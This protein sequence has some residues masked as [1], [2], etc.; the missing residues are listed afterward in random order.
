MQIPGLD[1]IFLA[2]IIHFSVLNIFIGLLEGYVLSRLYQDKE[3]HFPFIKMILSNMASLIMFIVGLYGFNVFGSIVLF[4]IVRW[5]FF[6]WVLEKYKS[7]KRDKYYFA[8]SQVAYS[9][10]IVAF[11]MLVLNT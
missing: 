3:L 11:Y 2:L 7:S 6:L 9:L 10:V 5:I 4:F 8:I 1:L